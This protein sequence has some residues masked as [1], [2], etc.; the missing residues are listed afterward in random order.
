MAGTVTESQVP[1]G[2]NATGNLGGI[3]GIKDWGAVVA[4][5]F[6]LTIVAI[7]MAAI[8]GYIEITVPVATVVTS[9]MGFII[10]RAATLNP[11][12]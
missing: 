2:E 1:T 8:L 7:V 11:T 4:I 12:N 6:A 3:L 5:I 10:G 9:M